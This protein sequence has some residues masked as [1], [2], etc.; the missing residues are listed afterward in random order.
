MRRKKGWFAL[1]M[2][3]A[4]CTVVPPGT[5]VPSRRVVGDLELRQ[6]G[7]VVQDLQVNGAIDVYA[8]DVV[9]RRVR[10]TCGP[11]WCIRQHDGASRLLVEDADLGPERTRST[12]DGVWAES[13]TG[14]RLVIHNVSDGMKAWSQVR[15]ESST[16]RS[17]ARAP[18]DHSDGVQVQAG[19]NIVLERNEIE[20]GTNAAVFVSSDSGVV[21]DVVVRNNRLVGGGFTFMVRTGPYGPP[22]RVELD[23][24]RFAGTPRYGFVSTDTSLVMTGNVRDGTN[25]PVSGN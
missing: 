24:N 8:S 15:L 2:L 7:E 5:T 4:A 10:V 1:F 6:A 25:R 17:L 9:I 23:A 19:T 16:I 13:F 18:G 11:Y 22:R 20:A 12:T 14:R 3:L 21:S